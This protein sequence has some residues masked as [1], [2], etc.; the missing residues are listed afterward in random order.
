MY[1]YIAIYAPKAS[2]R[3][4][5]I[6]QFETK[7][8]SLLILPF[9]L[10]EVGNNFDC[11]S[12]SE[13]KP[14]ITLISWH[15]QFYMPLNAEIQNCGKVYIAYLKSHFTIWKTHVQIVYWQLRQWSP[16]NELL[17]CRRRLIFRPEVGPVIDIPDSDSYFNCLR[18]RVVSGTKINSS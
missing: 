18:N 12:L 13:T 5:S 7:H 17:S 3:C 8:H 6:I 10:L 15:F 4:R 14:L 9:F 1:A 11:S 16:N 2:R